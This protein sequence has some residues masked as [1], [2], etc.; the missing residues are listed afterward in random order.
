MQVPCTKKNG[1]LG[2]NSN[3]ELQDMPAIIAQ[4]AKPWQRKLFL[5]PKTPSRDRDRQHYYIPTCQV[6]TETGNTTTAHTAQHAN[7]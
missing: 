6:L 7:C 2:E 3:D 4:Q 5:Q 1:L